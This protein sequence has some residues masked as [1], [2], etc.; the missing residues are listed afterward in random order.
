MMIEMVTTDTGLRSMWKHLWIKDG[1]SYWYSGC[2]CCVILQVS[3]WVCGDDNGEVDGD[4]NG[5]GADDDGGGAARCGAG[6]S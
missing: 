5:G 4:V 2:C 3:L 6:L 1:S